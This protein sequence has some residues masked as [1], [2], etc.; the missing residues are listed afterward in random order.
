MFC[1]FDHLLKNDIIIIDNQRSIACTTCYICLNMLLSLRIEEQWSISLIVQAIRRFIGDI[2]F[3]TCSG[4][5]TFRKMLVANCSAYFCMSFMQSIAIHFWH[6]CAFKY[7]PLL[8]FS[9]ALKAYQQSMSLNIQ[10][11]V[12]F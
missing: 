8:F 5:N 3:F 10:F 1:H 12:H 4:V 11:F 6:N 2:I 7:F 9:G